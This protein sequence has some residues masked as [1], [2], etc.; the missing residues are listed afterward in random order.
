[1]LGY[2]IERTAVALAALGGSAHRR[3][4]PRPVRDAPHGQSAMAHVRGADCFAQTPIIAI[5]T[6]FGGASAGSGEEP[7]AWDAVITDQ[8][9]AGMQGLAPAESG[10]ISSSPCAPVQLME[11]S[12]KRRR[13]R[14]SMPSSPS[15][16]GP[17]RSSPAGCSCSG[18]AAACG[19]LS[20]D[21]ASHHARDR[22]RRP[23][24]LSRGPC[25]CGWSGRFRQPRS[26]RPSCC[27]LAT[28]HP[29]RLDRIGGF[30]AAFP[31]ARVVLMSGLA[32][33]ADVTAV[34]RAGA[35]GFL[36]KTIA[37]DYFARCCR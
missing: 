21:C 18:R 14:A 13:C 26:R 15:R 37:P 4:D 3:V 1:V 27:A 2:F 29:A 19:M 8:L 22:C 11:S 17:I 34:V 30:V 12:V 6:L 35:L 5:S 31:Q 10:P 25:A 9:M 16:S 23:S 32:S 33:A 20:R 28:A 36:P 24:A 7:R